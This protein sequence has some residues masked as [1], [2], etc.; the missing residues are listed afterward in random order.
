MFTL[1]SMM[2][3]DVAKEISYEEGLVFLHHADTSGLAPAACSS[4]V[5]RPVV[6]QLIYWSKYQ[7]RGEWRKNK[8]TGHSL[9]ATSRPQLNVLLCSGS[10]QLGSVLFPFLSAPGYSFTLAAAA[11]SKNALLQLELR[12]VYAASERGAAILGVGAQP[13]LV[14]GLDHSRFPLRS[15]PFESSLLL[16]SLL[17]DYDPSGEQIECV[18]IIPAGAAAG[19]FISLYF[20]PLPRF[21]WFF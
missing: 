5:S 19:I 15:S 8:K 12:S 14:R 3:Q 2:I 18:M 1:N 4:P 6:I 7:S 21:F 16:L 20:T 13:R 10:A 9:R 17:D 11:K